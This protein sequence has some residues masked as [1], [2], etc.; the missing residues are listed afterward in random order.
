[1]DSE[2]PPPAPVPGHRIVTSHNAQ[3]IAV[4][5]SVEEIALKVRPPQ[6]VLLSITASRLNHDINERSHQQDGQARC[7]RRPY[8][9]RVRCPVRTITT[10]T[11]LSL[12]S[13]WNR[14]RLSE[15]ML[16][17]CREDGGLRTP[18]GD[19]GIVQ[20]GGTY[21]G[22]TMLGPGETTQWVRS[23]RDLP[24]LALCSYVASPP[25]PSR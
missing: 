19:M 12:S 17:A 14:K 8:G 1:M 9:L 25:A 6:L 5:K 18:D 10:S 16:T 7:S 22:V 4:V 20:R 15:R 3:G 11:W 13:V 23:A 24:S 21:C 2:Q